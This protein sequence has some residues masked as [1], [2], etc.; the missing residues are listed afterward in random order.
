MRAMVVAALLAACQG[1][2]AR[3][4][5][6]LLYRGA[7]TS[8]ND[9]AAL[10]DLLRREGLDYAAVD[11]ADLDDGRLRAARL[12][13]VP[14]GNFLDMGRGLGAGT[15]ARLRGAVH[16]GLG[17]LGICAGAFLAGGAPDYASL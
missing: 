8:P 6:I 3:R 14:G 10:E 9:V 7:G 16:A 4:A 12:L 15:P 11:A 5:P 2:P 17:Y 13:I 1:P